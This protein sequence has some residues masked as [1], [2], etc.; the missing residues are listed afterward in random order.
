MRRVPV[1]MAS[2]AASLLALEPA[3]R[4]CGCFTQ[5]S[6]AS[7]VL[8]AGERI[9]FS[10]DGEN[11]VAYI[12]IQ[13]QGRADQFGWIVPLPSVPTVELG[14]DELFTKLGGATQPSYQLTSTRMFCGGGSSSSSSSIGFG[15]AEE[16]ASI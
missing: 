13:Y 4:A 1:V 12:Q 15:C 5:P 11:V 8:Q 9:L 2:L 7:P 6:P 3:A 10:H 16:A 14:T